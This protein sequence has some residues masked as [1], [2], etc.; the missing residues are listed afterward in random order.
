MIIP[1]GQEA[2]N[3]WD[4]FLRIPNGKIIIPSSKLT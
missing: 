2:G 4:G 3:G 1:G